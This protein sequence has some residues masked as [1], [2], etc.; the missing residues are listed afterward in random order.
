MPDGDSIPISSMMGLAIGCGQGSAVG[1]WIWAGQSRKVELLPLGASQGCDSDVTADCADP[2]A[3]KGW[4]SPSH[5]SSCF[6]PRPHAFYA[7]VPRF[8]RCARAGSR[9]LSSSSRI[10]HP[11]LM[12]WPCSCELCGLCTIFPVSAHSNIT[13]S[14]KLGFLHKRRLKLSLRCHKTRCPCGRGKPIVTLDV[15]QGRKLVN[16]TR[17]TA[18]CAMRVGCMLLVQALVLLLTS[19]SDAQ[20]EL[21]C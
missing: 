10:F 11:L 20:L 9:G 3:R 21:V 19:S 17:R 4:C 2:A 7:S 14:G 18:V 16:I 13:G 15:E 12:V 8:S 1:A 6:C 5:L